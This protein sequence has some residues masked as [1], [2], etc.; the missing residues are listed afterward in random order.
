MTLLAES[1][2]LK[3]VPVAANDPVA[4]SRLGRCLEAAGALAALARALGEL[5]RAARTP[6]TRSEVDLSLMA[7]CLIGRLKREDRHRAILAVVH[8]GLVAQGDSRLL[9]IVLRHLLG[10]AWK[11]SS[12][13]SLTRIEVGRCRRGG[14]AAYYVTDNGVGFDP[15]RAGRLFRAFGRLHPPG[16]FGGSGLGLA[17]ARR[18]VRRHG[19]RMWAESSPGQGA[20]FYFTLREETEGAQ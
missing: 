13:R 11:F 16:D 14:I 1:R 3:E 18:I 2:Y 7:R 17:A 6:L 10:N 12:P 4:G 19:G 20:T 8:P 15:E 9:G 5:A